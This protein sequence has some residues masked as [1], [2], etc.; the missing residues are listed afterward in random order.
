MKNKTINLQ[1]ADGNVILGTSAE[2]QAAVSD[3]MFVF[4]GGTCT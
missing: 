1:P 3:D 2:W 4:G